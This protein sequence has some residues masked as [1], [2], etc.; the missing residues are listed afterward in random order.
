MAEASSTLCQACIPPG[1]THDTTDDGSTEQSASQRKSGGPSKHAHA[2][3]C[4]RLP[5]PTVC[6][7]H[8][9]IHEKGKRSEELVELPRILV[10]HEAPDGASRTRPFVP[11]GVIAPQTIFFV[12]HLCS[13]NSF[14]PSDLPTIDKK[15]TSGMSGRRPHGNLQRR[16]R[17]R[18]GW[19]R[20]STK[21]GSSIN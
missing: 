11:R 10:S 1:E 6:G 7:F 17:C 9:G 14:V 13:L 12:S 8:D 2:A 3:S 16:Q 19:L 21:A 20:N 15:L 5:I 18:G 4:P